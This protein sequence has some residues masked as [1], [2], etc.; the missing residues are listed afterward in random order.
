MTLVRYTTRPG[1]ADGNEAL[2]RAVF[3]QLHQSA[4]KEIA[5]GLFRN[6][7][8]FTHV[9]INFTKDDSAAVTELPA[10]VEFQKELATRCDVA[11]QIIRVPATLVDCYGFLR[12]ST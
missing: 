3:D 11:P 5:Y 6:G 2:A 9:F 7:D 8:E 4:P 10:F 1:R 12:S